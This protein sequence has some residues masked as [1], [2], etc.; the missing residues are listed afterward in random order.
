MIQDTT[1]LLPLSE[2]AQGTIRMVTDQK[3]E[4]EEQVSAFEPNQSSAWKAEVEKAV[5]LFSPQKALGV[6]ASTT[7]LAF[8][9]QPEHSEIH[10]ALPPD[11]LL[12]G[13]VRRALMYRPGHVGVPLSLTGTVIPGTGAPVWRKKLPLT[14]ESQQQGSISLG[15]SAALVSPERTKSMR[16]ANLRWDSCLELTPF[17]HEHQAAG[18]WYAAHFRDAFDCIGVRSEENAPSGS[19]FGVPAKRP[20]ATATL[21]YEYE[22]SAYTWVDRYVR[23][24]LTLTTCHPCLVSD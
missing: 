19:T 21:S 8:Q 14:E 22:S 17:G 7:T 13:P 4:R 3:R 18:I 12:R 20:T 16:S 10:P 1:H 9:D 15:S 5:V 24:W 2:A 11:L 6:P 23:L